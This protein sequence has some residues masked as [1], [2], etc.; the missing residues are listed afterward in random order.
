MEK[1]P[2]T[3]TSN[4]NQETDESDT[5]GELEY[6]ENFFYPE[7]GLRAWTQVLGSNLLNQIAWGYPSTYGVYQLYYTESMG[8]PSSQI[9]W[10]GSIQVFLAFSI[11]II[12]GR[13]SDA[14]YSRHAAFIGSVLTVLGTFITSL[15]TDYWQIL[16]AQGL[17]T[18]LGLGIMFMPGI[19]IVGSYFKERRALALSIAATGTG[20]GSCIFPATVNYLIPQ[21]GFPWA[22]RCQA[23][24]TFAV[25]VVANII[26]KP[27]LAPRKKG[28][29]VEWGAL[30]ESPYVLFAA[31]VFFVFWALYFSIF[32]INVFARRVVLFSSTDSVSL[33]LILNG[34]GIPSRLVAGVIADRWLGPINTLILT[35][36]FASITGLGWIGVHDRP[37]MYSLTTVFG[38]ANGMV[39]GVFGGA[40]ASLTE[41]PQRMGTRFGMVATI[42]GFATLAGPPTAGAI[43]D[44]SGGSF[45]W[46]QIWGGAVTAIGSLTLIAAR[47]TTTGL[48]WDAKL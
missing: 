19:A 36:I 6:D 46:A 35:T 42:V 27:R 32:Y 22:V 11:C 18:G 10:I 39:Q 47:I 40:L 13:L 15:C 43:I 9:S 45:L 30:R 7:G 5:E 31:G 37:G 24:L 48:V 16:L 29:L 38:W 33:L 2:T 34:M 17:C 21:I 8:L 41:D 1:N 12:S 20:I 44:Q 28:P 4:Q 23:F 3:A 26:L 25:A 14:G